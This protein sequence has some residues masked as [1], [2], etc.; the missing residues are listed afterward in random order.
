MLRVR[1]LLFLLVAALL[2]TSLEAQQPVFDGDFGPDPFGEPDAIEDAAEAMIEIEPPPRRQS[3]P[4]P[5]RRAPFPTKATESPTPQ[6][7]LE[8]LNASAESAARTWQILGK[9]AA[10][11][12]PKDDAPLRFVPHVMQLGKVYIVGGKQVRYLALSV[13]ALNRSE[14]PIRFERADLRLVSRNTELQLGD[15]PKQQG[16]THVQMGQEAASI[17][18]LSRPGTVT[19]PAGES[20]EVRTIFFN[21]PGATDIPEMILRLNI[22]ETKSQIDLNDYALG[23]MKLDVDRFGPKGLLGVVTVKGELT[24]VG[25]GGLIKVLETLV[26]DKTTRVILNWSETAPALDAEVA[27][28]LVQAATQL[29]VVQNSS[30][31]YPPLPPGFRELHL[32]SIPVSAGI[33]NYL[34]RQRVHATVEEAADAALQGAF[35]MIPLEALIAEI[36]SG[37]PLTRPAAVAAGK[38]LPEERLPLLLTL[39]S[40][41]NLRIAEA[42]VTALRGFGSEVAVDRLVELTQ[43]GDEALRAAAVKSLA[44]SRFGVAHE[45]LRTLLEAS[46]EGEPGIPPQ[47]L[48][49]V[50]ASH[51]RSLWGDAL[52]RIA[53]EGAPT[54]R[55]E[56]LAALQTLGHSKL[57]DAFRAALESD[58]EALRRRA[59]VLLVN[60]QN[61]EADALTVAYTLHHLESQPPTREMAALLQRTKD[62]RAIPL[63]IKHLESNQANNSEVVRLLSQIGGLEIREALENAYPKLDRSAQQAT[64]VTLAQMN[65]PRFHEFAAAALQSTDVTLIHAAQQ[66]LQADG[67]SKAVELLSKTLMESNQPHAI[68]Y[69]ASGLATIATLEARI[70]LRRTARKEG[71]RGQ[72]ALDAYRQLIENSPG[73]RA[74]SEAVAA[75]EALKW[76]GARDNYQLAVELDPQFIEAWAGLANAEMQLK[77]YEAAHG[78]YEKVLELDSQDT[79]AITCLAILQVMEGEVE[80]GLATVRKRAAQYAD[81]ELFAYNSAC[82]FAVASEALEK[83]DAPRAEELRVEAVGQL[84]RSVELGM[85]DAEEVAWMREDPD[86]KSLRGRPDFEKVVVA[87]ESRLKS[88][89]KP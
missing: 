77:N 11:Q 4:R 38:R 81:D 12:A 41:P 16:L 67:D 85:N 48:V 54:V 78:H 23:L 42:A 2:A 60:V 72:R 29:G 51:P 17:A 86:L 87:A 37:S 18:D 5:R 25:I 84:T 66:Q 21:L 46:A 36:E 26:V 30:G 59:F 24:T 9:P 7:L 61:P 75:A 53:M 74:G 52:F 31:Q 69:A 34:G 15:A 70:A 57:M 56:A 50:L 49:P 32:A 89:P 6:A 62:A 58:D 44:A 22:G 20:R 35:E 27:S 8:R 14:D 64:L 79:A 83:D 3:E 47:V 10:Q 65:S 63:L 28:W 39:T 76:E 55:A 45:A 80:E 43:R 71:Q 13:W 19:V 33:P 40:D 88:V 1:F 73:Q 68:Q 82:L